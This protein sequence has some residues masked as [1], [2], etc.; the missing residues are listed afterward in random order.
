LPYASGP[1]GPHPATARWPTYGRAVTGLHKRCM[2][3][4]TS[5]P[6]SRSRLVAGEHAVPPSPARAHPSLPTTPGG[7]GR[8]P[9][10]EPLAQPVQQP[11]DGDALLAH[12]VA[13][14]DRDR[15]VLQ[16]L[17]VDRH[18]VRGAD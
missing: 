2:C 7:P 18:A 16:R 3:A 4:T 15:A 17:E 5:P 8:R 14:A 13:L 11:R 12:R 10:R 9:L 1:Q 6:G